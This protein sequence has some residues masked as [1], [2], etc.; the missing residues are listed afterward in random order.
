MTEE[1]DDSS[2]S[3]MA[4]KTLTISEEAYNALVK[5]RKSGD[6][7]FTKIILRLT[8][9]RQDNSAQRLMDYLRSNPPS[10]DFVNRL[11][12]VVE[13]REKIH[14]RTY[15]SQDDPRGSETIIKGPTYDNSFCS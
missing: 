5:Q 6:E 3:F 11:R 4:H 12:E 2:C 8:N 1:M 9:Q 10:R 15:R 7:S 14:L 13:E